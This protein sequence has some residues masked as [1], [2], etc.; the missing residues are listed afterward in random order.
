MK[1]SIRFEG[2]VLWNFVSNYLNDS[3]DV[4]QFKRTG[5]LEPSVRELNF[6]SLSVQSMSKKKMCDFVF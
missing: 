6:N 1:H 3:H 5:N 2:G 4:K